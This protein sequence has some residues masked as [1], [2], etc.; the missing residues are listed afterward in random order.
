MFKKQIVLIILVFLGLYNAN[1]QDLKFL[2]LKKYKVATLD[3]QLNETSGLTEIGGKLLSFNDSGNS[4]DIYE[5]DRE[6]G[7]VKK[8]ATNATNF[9]WEAI[10]TD[11]KNLY[12][13]DFGNNMGTRSNLMVY[14]IPFH[15]GEPSLK[16]EKMLRFY[17]PNQEEFV[18]L[19]RKNNFD[20]ESM[21]YHQGNIQIFSKEWA[22]YNT[23]HY[24]IK[25]DTEERQPAVLL[26]EYPLGYLATD[27]TYKDGKLYIIGYTKK[28]EVY[29]TVFQETAPNRFFEAKPQ[30]YYLGMSFKLGQIEGITATEKGLYISGERFKTKIKDVK[31]PLYFVPYNKLK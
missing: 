28:A 29:L 14:K 16:Y 21:I 18:P 4:A 24:E 1:A 25:T 7:N 5:I 15:D 20:A 30:K 27:A 8:I 22:S 13:G 10:S 26:E 31:Q 2:K 17:Y 3:K 12:I 23:R 6:N 9:D 19:N 11:G